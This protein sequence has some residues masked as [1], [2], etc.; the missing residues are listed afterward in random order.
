[1]VS[2]KIK[3]IFSGRDNHVVVR[4]FKSYETYES[5]LTHDF[6]YYEPGTTTA[7]TTTIEFDPID[8]E[9]SFTYKNPGL[10]VDQD[11]QISTIEIYLWHEAIKNAPSWVTFQQ[12][13][14]KYDVTLDYIKKG[15]T[16]SIFETW[17]QDSSVFGNGV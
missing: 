14:N 13:A 16:N 15:S 1:M 12:N 17:T 9:I 4:I 10:S 7:F 6:V 11:L 2:R 5:I 3:R 8:K